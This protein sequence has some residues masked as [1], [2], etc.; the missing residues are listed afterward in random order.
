MGESGLNLSKLFGNA[1]EAMTAQREEVNA[2]DGYNGNH[3]DNM[4]DGNS[5]FGG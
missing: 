1:L 5:R 4:V 3:G 2:M